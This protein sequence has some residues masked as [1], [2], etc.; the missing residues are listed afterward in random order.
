MPFVLKGKGYLSGL[1]KLAEKIRIKFQKIIEDQNKSREELQKSMK[2]RL[3]LDFLREEIG[4]EDDLLTGDKVHNPS[5]ISLNPKGLLRDETPIPERIC[6]LMREAKILKLIVG[7]DTGGIYY[8]GPD[9]PNKEL[10]A[11][12]KFALRELAMN[13]MP[14]DPQNPKTIDLSSTRKPAE[15]HRGY[16]QGI[17]VKSHATLYR[18]SDWTAGLT[19]YYQIGTGR[20]LLSIVNF[21]GKIDG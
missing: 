15:K 4:V 16:Q 19:L 7:V 13:G 5:E 18:E 2:K 9:F 1:D 21:G 20:I 3:R 8:P 17:E 10:K 6:K 11:A 14:E 12:I